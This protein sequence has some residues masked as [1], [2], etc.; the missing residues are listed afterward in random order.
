[1]KKVTP[2]TG[3]ICF[4]EIEY[5]Q[6]QI[7]TYRRRA[8]ESTERT[9]GSRSNTKGS[10]NQSIPSARVNTENMRVPKLKREVFTTI[11]EE[12]EPHNGFA[13]HVEEKIISYLTSERNADMNNSTYIHCI[14]NSLDLQ[15]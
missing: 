12:P 4:W 7:Y 1:M 8:R 10:I 3:R 13:I 9:T 15:V 11:E 6:E 5:M 14:N 2:L